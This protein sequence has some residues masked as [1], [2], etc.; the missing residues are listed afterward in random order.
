[1]AFTA[2]EDFLDQKNTTDLNQG[3]FFESDEAVEAAV[4]PLYN[5]VW[6]A[7]NEKAYYAFGDGRSNNITAQYSEYIKYYGNLNETSLTEGLDGAWNA[8]YSVRTMR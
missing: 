5:Y 1:M 2:C 3:T 8:L 4:Y 7:F 6:W